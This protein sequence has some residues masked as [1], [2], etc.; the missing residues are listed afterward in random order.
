MRAIEGFAGALTEDYSLQLD[1]T[2]RSYLA[3]ISDGAVRM[4]QLINDLLLHARLGQGILEFGPVDMVE[5]V[6][7]AKEHLRTTVGE[8]RAT[9]R[10]E[11]SLPTVKGHRGTLVLLIQNL[12]DNAMKFVSR[13]N[14]PE[15]A[16]SSTEDERS[17]TI[18]VRDSGIGIEDQ[19][20]DSIFKIFERLHTRDAFPGTGIGLAIVK[21]AATIH[22]GEVWVK[23]KPGVGSTFHVRVPKQLEKRGKES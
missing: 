11:G 14:L 23:S 4:E 8:S 6:N 3:E 13:G 17:H 12:L 19:F 5:V 16:I 10:V 1:E 9:I 7:R 18:S 22:G 20:H 2:A 15:V 21:K